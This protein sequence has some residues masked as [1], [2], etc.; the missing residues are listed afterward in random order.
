M[1][2]IILKETPSLLLAS[3]HCHLR[4]KLPWSRQWKMFELPGTRKTYFLKSYIKKK[5]L[6][7]YWW[8][9]TTIPNTT[10]VSSFNLIEEHLF[11][12]EWNSPGWKRAWTKHACYLQVIRYIIKRYWQI[13]LIYVGFML[14]VRR[15]VMKGGCTF[16]RG[17]S[18][19]D[20][21]FTVE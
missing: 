9:L 17:G 18:A 13:K 1:F 6:L 7:K 3:D 10:L 11:T 19:S 4:I 21:F 16:S 14:S 12:S 5:K 20:E 2:I 8:S 15:I